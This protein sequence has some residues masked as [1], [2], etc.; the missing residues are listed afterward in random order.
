VVRLDPV[1]PGHLAKRLAFS[2]RADRL[3]LSACCPAFGFAFRDE[4]AT[5]IERAEAIERDALATVLPS[6]RCTTR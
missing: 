6:A 2:L 3:G 4:G 5:L 1:E